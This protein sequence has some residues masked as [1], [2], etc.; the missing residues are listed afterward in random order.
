MTRR[1]WGREPAGR[2][3]TVGVF[4]ELGNNDDFCEAL[5]LERR[6]WQTLDWVP[7]E[8]FQ[9]RRFSWLVESSCPL[10]LNGCE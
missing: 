1:D 2:Q 10:D 5:M 7:G 3:F 4:I 8:A 6:Y 9:S